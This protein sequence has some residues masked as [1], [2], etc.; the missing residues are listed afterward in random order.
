M[1]INHNHPETFLNFLPL[2]SNSFFKQPPELSSPVKPPNPK[3][4]L[5]AS[6]L[7]LQMASWMTGPDQRSPGKAAR[8]PYGVWNKHICLVRGDPTSKQ[9]CHWYAGS[10]PKCPIP[11]GP[12]KPRIQCLEAWCLWCFILSQGNKQHLPMKGMVT[13][14]TLRSTSYIA[15]LHHQLWPMI[16]TYRSCLSFKHSKHYLEPCY[17][18]SWG[19]SFT[20]KP[21]EFTVDDSK[22]KA[23]KHMTNGFQNWRKIQ[24]P[25]RN[26]TSAWVHVLICCNSCVAILQEIINISYPVRIVNSPWKD[27]TMPPLPN[28]ENW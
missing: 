1:Y 17:D 20:K 5:T 27:T 23:T 12:A 11:G 19:Y 3:G 18:T 7:P 21:W 15:N 2:S 16:E 28:Q 10:T 24:I 22:F 13:L 4:Y 8:N 25:Y 26:G 9:G 14:R 6:K